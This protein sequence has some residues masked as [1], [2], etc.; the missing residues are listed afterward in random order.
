[1]RACALAL[2][3]LCALPLLAQDEEEYDD[4]SP[5]PVM[6]TVTRDVNLHR[7]PGGTKSGTLREQTSVEI[8]GMSRT[9]WVRVGT[10]ERRGWVDRRFLQLDDPTSAT[11]L[12]PQ[13]FAR[14]KAKKE[15]PCEFAS[16]DD[17]PE[18]GC[19]SKDSHH[20]QL[21]IAKHG[22][23][24][25]DVRRLTFQTFEAL[26]RAAGDEVGEGAKI[27]DRATIRD[28]KVGDRRL[29]EGQHVAIAGYI[30]GHAHANSSGE[31]VNCKL[32]T[33]A[34]N[35]FHL[36]LASD[37]DLSEFESIV[38]EMIPRNRNP[39]WTVPKLKRVA[40]ARRRVLAVGHLF[41]DNLHR[42]NKNSRRNIGGQPKRFS[43]WEIHPVTEFYVCE[44]ARCDA[45]DTDDWTRLED[46]QPE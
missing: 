8:L 38:V 30:V 42:V 46:F 10:G 13:T 19:S 39:E 41:Y 44:K 29:G 45:D 34:N 43:L 23:P 35:D 14:A 16:L 32:K 27:E 25:G 12:H 40:E 3:L 11:P 9:G 20:G 1:M 4:P 18:N 37:P 24:V 5:E 33:Q 15:E 28:L 2:I 17:C 31:G 22:I 26:Q 21:N 7:S 36:N 6:A